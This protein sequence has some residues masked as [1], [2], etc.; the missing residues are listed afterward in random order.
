MQAQDIELLFVLVL[1]L[2][3]GVSLYAVWLRLHLW[4]TDQALRRIAVIQTSQLQN[5]PQT[6]GGCILPMVLVGSL[7][8]I[9]LVAFS[10]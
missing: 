10:G 2:L 4:F 1:F 9:T 5:E 3:A 8:V 7:A 6:T